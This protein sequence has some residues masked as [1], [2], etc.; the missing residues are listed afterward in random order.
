MVAMISRSNI[1]PSVLN[2]NSA[3]FSSINLDELSWAEAGRNAGLTVSRSKSYGSIASQIAAAQKLLHE[4]ELSPEKMYVGVYVPITLNDGTVKYH[5]V[6][7]DGASMIDYDGLKYLKV[8]ATSTNDKSNRESN[9]NWKEIDGDMYV[10]ADSVQGTVTANNSN[11]ENPS[12]DDDD[13]KPSFGD[14][15]KAVINAIVSFFT[16]S[17][18]GK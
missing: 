18:K 13:N 11:P 15:V 16:G 9:P 2:N 4:A 17:D 12:L 14:S 5:W 3:N 7:V 1:N 10:R 6:G 8:S